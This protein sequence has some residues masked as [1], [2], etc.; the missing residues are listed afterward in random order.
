MEMLFTGYYFSTDSMDAAGVAKL[1]ALYVLA[2]T[3]VPWLYH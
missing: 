3:D 1:A 2:N